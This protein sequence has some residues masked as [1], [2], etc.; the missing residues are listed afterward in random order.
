M[1]SALLFLTGLESCPRFHPSGWSQFLT[2][3]SDPHHVPHLPP[4]AS[5]LCPALPLLCPPPCTKPLTLFD[6]DQLLACPPSPHSTFPVLWAFLPTPVT[7]PLTTGSPP[8]L[9]SAHRQ[10]P[11]SLADGI[12]YFQKTMN[13]SS[14]PFLSLSQAKNVCLPRMI[15]FSAVP[16]CQG[17][18]GRTLQSVVFNGVTET[19]LPPFSPLLLH[20]G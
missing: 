19:S 2:A 14:L 8:V 15:Q 12:C 13:L 11:Q 9:L 3:L 5:F 6:G 4:G 10:L 7:R 17:A 1:F 20:V 18:L 16:T